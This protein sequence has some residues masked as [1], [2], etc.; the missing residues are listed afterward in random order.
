MEQ[1]GSSGS[2]RIATAATTEIAGAEA[3]ATLTESI[4]TSLGPG[5]VDL[6]FLFTT[7]HFEESIRELAAGIAESL[8][9]RSFAGTTGEAVICNDKEL[10][11]QPAAVLWAARLP[12]ARVRTFHLF[13]TDLERIKAGDEFRDWVGAPADDLPHFVLLA[14]PFSLNI[15]ELLGRFERAY[16]CRPVIGGLASAADQPKQN[17]VIFDGEV[18]AEG[19]VGVSISGNV[20][21]EPVVSQGCRPIA[22]HLVITKAERNVIH[23]LGGRNALSV[24][25]EVLEQCS[26]EERQLANNGMFVGRAVTETHAG[27]SRGHFLIR[28]LLGWDHQSGA[29]AINDFVRTGQTIQF[30]VRDARTA[31]E[32]LRTLVGSNAQAPSAGALLFTC[33]GRGT[34]MFSQ[35]NHDAQL[36]S[37]RGSLPVAGFFC[38]GEI[39]P[40]GPQSFVHGHSASVA[41]FRPCSEAESS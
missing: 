27:F 29:I 30:H 28:N 15:L 9:P 19:A 31:G 10:E 21:V 41:Y 2:M 34:R 26:P 4:R 17:R 18:L 16:P 13:Q 7:A 20:R 37:H 23:E 12:G 35:R 39:G 22:R 24:L 36:V 14:D 25:K 6:A 1:S 5:G 8:S 11:S 38:A 3:A 40:V 33:N 32:D